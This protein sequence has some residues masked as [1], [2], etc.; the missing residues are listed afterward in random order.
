M[1]LVESSG[2]PALDCA[3]SHQ[4]TLSHSCCKVCKGKIFWKVRF[5][6]MSHSRRQFQ[7]TGNKTFYREVISKD[8]GIKIEML[9]CL[10]AGC[11]VPGSK[12]SFLNSP[13]YWFWISMTLLKNTTVLSYFIEFFCWG[14]VQICFSFLFSLF[15]NWLRIIPMLATSNVSLHNSTLLHWQASV[16]LRRERPTN[17]H[18]LFCVAFVMIDLQPISR[19]NLDF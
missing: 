19:R 6:C 5:M 9:P 14:G 7:L 18:C 13:V 10:S 8:C 16:S 1:K 17:M 4:I 15:Y 3:E 2:C 11:L 12:S